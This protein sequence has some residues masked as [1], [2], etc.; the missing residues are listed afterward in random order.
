MTH[1]CT[2][3]QRALAAVGMTTLGMALVGSPAPAARAASGQ[4]TVRLVDADSQQPIAARM[5]L[6]GAG[7]KPFKPPKTAFWK[8]HFPVDGA[9]TFT[10]RPGHY[11]FELERG[12][13]YK[14]VDGHFEIRAG[15]E[16]TKVVSMSRFVD[17]ASQGWWSGDLHVHRKLVDIEPLM[18]AD[19]LHIAPVITWWN[20]HGRNA[21]A[22]PVARPLVTF[23]GN[24]Y[25]TCLLYTSPSPRD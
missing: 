10:L 20:A 18:R 5:H 19:D 24:R 8:D 11:Q 22:G 13:E 17:M 21:T 1:R 12:P 2:Q 15:A 6:R 9:M 4:L 3:T 25:Y 16:D 7:G 14:S 23:D